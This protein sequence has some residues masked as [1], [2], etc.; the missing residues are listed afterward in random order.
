MGEETDLIMTKTEK[1]KAKKRRKI[2]NFKDE[3]DLRKRKKGSPV[4][5][6]VMT[7]LALF[8]FIFFYFYTNIEGVILA[9][10]DLNGSWTLGNF[11]YIFQQFSSNGGI[12][13]ESLK[14][15]PYCKLK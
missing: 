9:F 6:L 15:T 10:K 11:E 1:A 4:F 5:I 12:M 3:G 13:F 8:N 2:F 14:N 7:G